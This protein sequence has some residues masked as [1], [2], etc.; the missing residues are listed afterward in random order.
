VSQPASGVEGAAFSG[1][2][3]GV[4]GQAFPDTDAE[5]RRLDNGLEVVLKVDRNA[6][7]ASV[8][9]WVRTGSIH[10]ADLLGSG[11][12][13]LV[14]H[15][16]FK[17]TG[18]R[19]TNTIAR[20]VQ[21]VGGYLNAYTSFDRTV[22]W[23]ETP[24]E[25]VAVALDV[26]ADIT[27][28]ATMPEEDFEREKDVIRREI[29]MGKDDPG[30][31]SSQL[32]FSTV[33]AEHPSREPVIG[34]LGL[35]NTVTRDQA[36][37]YY[38]QRYAPN[39]MFVVVVG[40]VDAAALNAQIDELF[41][42]GERGFL[43][44]ATVPQEPLQLGRR[45]VHEEFA[46]Q[47]TKLSLAW[48]IPGMAHPDMPA[49]DVLASVLGAG[50][51]SR[52]YSE[53]REG[54]KLAHSVGSY[55]YTPST[56]GLFLVYADT[57]PPDRD[58]VMREVETLVEQVKIS[59]VT[60]GE[61]VKARKSALAE[62]IDT[63]ATTR[64]IASD[65]GSNWMLTRN[66]NFTRDYIAA[67][68]GVTAEDVRRVARKYLLEKTLTVCSLNPKGN[69]P[70][71]PVVAGVAAR[72]KVEQTE[73]P[74]GLTLLV[75][76][77]PRLPSVSVYATFLGGILSES[78]AT[79]GLTQLHAR[80]VLKGTGTR[81][82]SDVF[83][84]IENVGGDIG[85]SAGNNSF[86]V[87]ASFMAGDLPMGINV[88]SDVLCGA[89]FPEEEI[90]REKDAQL[91]K[92]KSEEDHLVTIAFREL[93]KHV[94]PGHLYALNRSGSPGSIASLVHDQVTGFH[95]D[96][97]CGK[98]GVIAVYGDV[99]AE[100]V[101]YLFTDS[102]GGMSEGV[103]AFGSA[104]PPEA[105]VDGGV[106]EL[107]RDKEQ[108]VLAVG[109]RTVSVHDGDRRVLDLINEACSD[110]A[111]RLFVRIREE[112]GLAYYVGS[113]QMIGLVGG[114]FVFYLGTAPEQLDHAQRELLDE[115][116]KMAE[117]GFGNDELTRAK[118][119]YLGKY[120]IELQSNMALA[121]TNALD[122]LFGF[123][124]D[125]YLGVRDEV[126]KIGAGDVRRVAAKYFTGVE[127]VVVRVRP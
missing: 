110:M 125:R 76:E 22:Y 38:R 93:R 124:H 74:N 67:I 80:T 28:G 13:H 47:L 77:D 42:G 53:L 40:D 17:G 60:D 108:A 85:A 104:V 123:G 26:L 105:P 15:M 32:L 97:V 44:G 102:L 81:S 114:A 45:E 63:L 2:Q 56:E 18:K 66:L 89:T 34:H 95:R 88:L 36:Y 20:D 112:Q 118:K 122:Q 59:G 87:S 9:V 5:V 19:D 50:R 10:E 25:G 91:A 33:F 52:L 30:R 11:V 100:E 90:V 7:V 121:Q 120:Q 41:G 43:G 12:S 98:N 68:G 4:V 16:V 103:R 92:L 73:L 83:S 86:A 31:Q 6:P 46:T 48:R 115:V 84:E 14:E 70:E 27:T 117:E 8:Q 69:S 111:S 126:E 96:H 61:M 106:Y 79:S 39:N 78:S 62:Q 1:G 65:L 54:K 29:S 57:D 35:F 51:S 21:D 94:F 23:I 55:A 49:L 82:A 71:A 24:S 99:S 107:E 119:T 72:L 127:P 3:G 75:R 64:G 101:R 109:F 37:G 58:T 116:Q 113:S